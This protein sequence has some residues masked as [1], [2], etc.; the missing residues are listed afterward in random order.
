M[1]LQEKIRTV[2]VNVAGRDVENESDNVGLLRDDFMAVY[3]QDGLGCKKRGSFV[4]I[5]KRVIARYAIKIS[6]GKLEWVIFTIGSLVKGKRQG[7]LKCVL[8][9][10]ARQ[11][12]MFSKLLPMHDFNRGSR[13]PLDFFHLASSLSAT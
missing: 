11:A 9:L 4:S 10:Q 5:R 7:C 8:I 3:E 13:Q 12:P 1:V 2:F 6:C